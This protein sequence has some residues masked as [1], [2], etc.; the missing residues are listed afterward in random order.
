M[1]SPIPHLVIVALLTSTCATVL[2]DNSEKSLVDAADSEKLR[3][4]GM[5]QLSPDGRQV[6]FDE[7]GTIF[8]SSLDS[9]APRPVTGESSSASNPRWSMDGKHL[10][11]L[12]D[13]SEQ[14][15]LWRLSIERFGEAEQMSDAEYGLG[16][17]TLS[18]DETRVLLELTDDDLLHDENAEDDA[19]PPP[20]VLSRQQFKRDA[21]AGYLTAG[22]SSHLHIY[23]LAADERTQ[24]TS[25]IHDES[26]ASWSPDSNSIVFVSN[27]ETNFDA[28]YRTDIFTVAA[29]KDAEIKRLTNDDASKHSPAWSPDGKHIA[30]ISGGDGVYS[31]QQLAL[32]PADGGDSRI[33]T[34]ELDRWVSAFEF[35]AD[36]RYIYFSFDT[37]GAVHLARLRLRDGHIEKLVEG[38]VTVNAFDVGPDDTVAINMNGPVDAGEIRLLRRGRLIDLTDL[39]RAYFDEFLVADK[40]KVSFESKDGTVVEAFITFPPGYLPGKRYPAIL[41][42][43]GGPVGQF[44]WGYSFRAQYLAANGY[45][46]IEPNPRGSTGFGEEYVR[47]IYRTWGITDYDDVIAAVDYAIAEGIADPAR[48][49]VTGYSYGGYMTNVVITNTDR[50][51]AAASGAGHSLIEANFGHDIYQQWYTWELGVPWENR[52][53]YDVLSPFL[54][55]GKVTTPTIFLGGRV[56][57]NVPILNAELMYQALSVRGIDT[58]LVV[59][60][61]THHG[62]WATEYEQDYL[63]RILAWFD[64]YL[65]E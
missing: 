18:P 32:V 20:F 61:D 65:M 24:I 3:Y 53:K 64:R 13:R 19:P 33:L 10:Y 58:E 23:D 27:R 39:N 22:Q 48:L 37:A 15:Q 41:N 60:P 43:H 29:T 38:E 1:K 12:S 52:E 6:A 34:A 49:A 45:V 62:G 56:D 8:I 28:T 16:S 44:S 55:A 59:Y 54:R 4:V 50:F 9:P 21:G 63:Q 47:A 14:N 42:V 7:D 25:G 46:V 2:A 36:G 30:Y 51:K 57:W 17:A 40:R 5:P 26:D 11:F 31:V 35:S